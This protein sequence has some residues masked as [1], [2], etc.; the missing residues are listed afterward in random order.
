M[1]PEQMPFTHTQLV[2]WLGE[3]TAACSL[4][5]FFLQ[6]SAS[7]WAL[8]GCRLH[9]SLGMTMSVSTFFRSVSIPSAAYDAFAHQRL[10]EMH[11]MF[12][13]GV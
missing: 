10:I 8:A 12:E 7:F 2:C 13:Y 6:R 3:Q 5:E 9:L 11:E 1:C 4:H